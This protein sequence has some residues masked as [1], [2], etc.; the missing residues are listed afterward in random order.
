MT[1]HK[2]FTLIE[3]MITVAVLA[4]LVT[5]AAPSFSEIIAS[6]R[7]RAAASSL[8]DTVLLARSEAIKRNTKITVQPNSSDFAKGWDVLLADNTTSIKSHEALNGVT[9]SFSPSVTKLEYSP[10]GRPSGKTTATL[11]GAGTTKQWT[12]IIEASGRVCVVEGAGSC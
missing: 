12:V 9:V 10:L 4:V 2:G 11:S 8:Y 6:Q 5:L 1:S 3:L 7:I